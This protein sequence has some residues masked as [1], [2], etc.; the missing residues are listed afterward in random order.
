MHKSLEKLKKITIISGHILTV[1]QIISIILILIVSLYWFFELTEIHLLDFML[2]FIDGIKSSMQANFGEQ[3]KKGQA[4]LDGSLFIFIALTGLCIYIIAQ[5]KIFASHTE[6]VL[7]KRIIITKQKEEE[8]FNIQLN[9]EKQRALMEY[10][11]IV[12]LISISLKSL[13]K[14]MYQTENDNKRIDKRQEDAALVAFYNMLKTIPGCGFS[15]DGSTLII[16]AKRFELVDIILLKIDESLNTLKREYK[17]KKIALN[18]NMAID[19]YTNKVLLKDVYADLKTLLTLN[20][21]NE[22]LCYGNFCNR[23]ELMKKP[24]F[25]AYLKGTYDITDDE[26]IWA[27]VKKN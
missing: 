11:N 8:A 19:V 5:L 7:T 13:L 15:K 2:P 4:G 16:T 21:P 23:Y 17:L 27:L 12:I 24:Q 25:E 1:L 26:N 14:D 6:K 22:I 10:K 20:M 9:L 18:A 3:L